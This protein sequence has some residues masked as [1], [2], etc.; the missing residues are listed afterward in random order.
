MRPLWI[1]AVLE[2]SV[3]YFCGEICIFFFLG[4]SRI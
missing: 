3:S 4:E 1:G 2:G